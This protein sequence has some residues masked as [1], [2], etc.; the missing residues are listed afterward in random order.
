V[1]NDGS[2]AN[3]DAADDERADVTSDSEDAFEDTKGDISLEAEIGLDVVQ[4]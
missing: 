3:R 4:E 2:A 1:E